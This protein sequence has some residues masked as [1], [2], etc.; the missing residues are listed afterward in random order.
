MSG[1]MNT[2]PLGAEDTAR[3]IEFAR[4]CKAAARAVLLYPPAHPAISATLGRIVQSTSVEALHRPLKL[5]VLPDNVLP[6]ERPAGRPP[7]SVAGRTGS[8]RTI[9]SSARSLFIRAA[10]SMPADLPSPDG[11]SPES[12]RG[13][14]GLPRLTMLAGRHI[15][16]REIDYTQVLRERSP[17]ETATQVQIIKNRL[18]GTTFE[19]DEEGVRE[20]LAITGDAER[21]TELMTTIEG[22]S[23]GF[24]NVSSKTA[25]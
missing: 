2:E 22:R 14:G 5:T 24:G 4:A 20:L 12:V 11:R 8:A 17:S 7:G 19:L 1:L 25:R 3:L 13:E 16:L 10:T 18:E 15:D 23:S 6:L 21:L 9:I